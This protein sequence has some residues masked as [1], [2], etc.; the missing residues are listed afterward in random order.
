MHFLNLTDPIDQRRRFEQQVLKSK[1][2]GDEEAM[3]L[4]MIILML[5]NMVFHQPAVLE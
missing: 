3:K 2:E 5:L 4:I 1:A